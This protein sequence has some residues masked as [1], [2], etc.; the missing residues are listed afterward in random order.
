MTLAAAPLNFSA[1]AYAAESGRKIDPQTWAE[2][3]TRQ[4]DALK[5][6][7]R[8]QQLA[9]QLGTDA[10]TA[11]EQMALAQKIIRNAAELEEAEGVVNAYTESIHYL[12]GLKT[13]SKV[14]M[15][16]WSIAAT[17]G[18]S[19]AL[20]EGTGLLVGGVDCIVDVTET[21]STLLLGENNQVAVAFGDIKEK[22]GPVSSLI[23]LATLNPSA[24]GK[25]AKD[26]T[27]AMVYITDSLVDLFY[28]DKIVGIKVEGLSE[29]AVS[30]SGQV[31]EAGAKAALEAAGYVL[32]ENETIKALSDILNDRKPDREQL[33]ARLDALSARMSELE[34]TAGITEEV[35]PDQGNAESAPPSKVPENTPAGDINIFGRYTVGTT[36]EDGE[37]D[38]MTVTL[39]DA[40]GGYVLWQTEGDEYEEDEYEEDDGYAG[41]ATMSYNESTHTLHYKGDWTVNVT[42]VNSEGTVKGSGYMSGILWEQSFRL[43]LDFTKISD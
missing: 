21:G 15:L 40:G 5:G 36:S 1:V 27:E 17:G 24:I 9:Q 26:T 19:V 28:E 38:T 7:K 37:T 22:L 3:L 8:Y 39:S 6:A 34:Q 10:K 2:S 4:Y 30:I 29:Q 13:T 23:G 35:P 16:G 41:R 20:L 25:T 14:A 43:A 31:F 42:F 32:P 12:Q 18:G 11:Y 33:R